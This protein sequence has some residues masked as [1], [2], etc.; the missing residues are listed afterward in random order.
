MITIHFFGV[1]PN[2]KE[3]N[4]SARRGFYLIII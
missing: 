4:K 1:T 3:E 2:W